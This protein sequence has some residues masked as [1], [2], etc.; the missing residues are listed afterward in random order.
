M[1]WVG[2]PVGYHQPVHEQIII[3]VACAMCD[4]GTQMKET[5]ILS[6]SSCL[7]SSM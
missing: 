7:S 4:L 5:I 6:T 2:V 3:H 1:A